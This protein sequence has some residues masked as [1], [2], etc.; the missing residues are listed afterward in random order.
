MNPQLVI[1]LGFTRSVGKDTLAALL[2]AIDP[3]FRS[4]AFARPLK[5]DLA[6]FFEQYFSIDIWNCSAAEKE[7]V[8]PL[9]IS[10]GM[11]QR[12][13]D[14]DYWVKRTLSEVQHGLADSFR[15]IIPVITDVRFANE[16][17]LMRKTFPHFKMIYVNRLGAP[18]PTDEEEKH[19]RDLIPLADYRLD[20]GENSEAEQR[21]CAIQLVKWLEAS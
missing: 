21:S 15:E 17:Q 11:A 2:H 7:L 16:E 5:Q 14:P 1:G 19:Y 9:L 12:A 4:Y 10:Y 8:R 20:W 13:R 18:S 6:L 3:R